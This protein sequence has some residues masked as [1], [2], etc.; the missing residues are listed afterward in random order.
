M[1]SPEWPLS[2]I[3]ALS[4]KELEFF[5]IESKRRASAS[6]EKA[7]MGHS[8]REYELTSELNPDR[9][10]RLFIRQST[11]HSGV[12]SVGLALILDGGDLILCRYNSGHHGHRNI[13]EKQ[14]LP[15]TFHKHIATARYIA[16]GL[17]PDGYAEATTDYSTAQGALSQMLADCAILGILAPQATEDLF[18]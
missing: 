9:R 17:D 18:K 1:S 11:S 2:D 3:T 15:P 4:D 8:G 7:K 5:R 6:R 16:A 13:L 10:F 14:K 12:F